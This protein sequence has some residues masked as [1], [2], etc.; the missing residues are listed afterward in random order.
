MQ[1]G[2]QGTVETLGVEIF[3]WGSMVVRLQV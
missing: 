2:G 3:R 1:F